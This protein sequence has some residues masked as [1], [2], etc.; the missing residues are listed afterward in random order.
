MKKVTVL[1]PCYNEE[2][3]LG[4][5]IDGIPYKK[6][7]ALGYKTEVI[8][9][10]NNSSDKTV[11]VAKSKNARVIHEPRQGK[12]Y[13]MITGFKNIPKD[14]DKVVMIDGDATYKSSEMLRLIEPLDS[15]FCDVVIGTRLSGK[16]KSNSMT[17]FNRFGNWFL[18]FLVRVAYRGN[19]TDVCT[20][21]FAWN[22]YVID[23]LVDQLESNGFS[24]EMEMVTKMAK[25]NYDIYSV[26]IT[27][28]ERN[29]SPSKLRP[30]RDGVTIFSTWMRNL[31]WK[32]KQTS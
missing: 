32:P 10:D 6:L 23:A 14:T 24:I 25:M 18:T 22:R 30:M 16:I 29:G 15:G 21:Y 13:A 12:G 26:P 5:V 17:E 9:I 1:V 28:D 11:R 8:V 20:G 27:Y 2:E 3:G 4:S 19:V 7:K 31:Y